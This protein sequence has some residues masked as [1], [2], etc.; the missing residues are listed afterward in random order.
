MKARNL[1][2]WLLLFQGMFLSFEGLSQTS[3][4]PKPD[5]SL[6][7]PLSPPKHP[8]T[9]TYFFLWDQG[10]HLVELVEAGEFEQASTL[11]SMHRDSFFLT[12]KEKFSDLVDR[13]SIGLDKT[14]QQVFLQ[15][16]SNLQK[17][18]AEN[19]SS[20]GP[21]RVG[22]DAAQKL[23]E[24][25]VSLPAIKDASKLP[26][27][28]TALSRAIDDAR[29]YWIS[30]AEAAFLKFDTKRNFF[31]VYPVTPS[32]PSQFLGK[33]VPAK[34]E[35]LQSVG[36]ET[37]LEFAKQYKSQLASSSAL[38][39]LSDLYVEVALRSVASPDRLK[40]A[41]SAL[42]EAREAGLK[43][44]RVPGLRIGFVEATSQTLLKEGQIEFPVAIEVNLP[45][46]VKKATLDEAL[47]DGPN[48]FDYVIVVDVN[49][50][51]TL[52]R[53][54]KRDEI[55]SEFLAGSRERPN[56]AYEQA[57]MA[58]FQAQSE[59][60]NQQGQYCYGYGCIAKAIAV[61]IVAS[62]LQERQNI[63]ASTPM[64]ITDPVYNE[65]KFSASD[66][67]ARKA[68][69]AN[70]YVIDL[71]NRV[72]FKSIFEVAEEKSFKIAYRL[73]EKDKNLS[74]HLRDYSSESAV[75]AFNDAPS[76]VRLSDVLGQYIKNSGQ[77]QALKSA[78]AMRE[79]L[80]A[81]KNVALASYKETSRLQSTTASDD[82]RLASVV[83]IH[84][85]KGS[86]GTG[87]FVESD[88]VLTN[89]H[90][91]EGSQFVEMKL[92]SGLETFGKVVKTDA[93]LDLALVKV[94][95][96]GA[97]VTF[98]D[99]PIPLG[100]TVEAIGH[101][102][103]LNFSITRG[104]ISAV[105]KRPALSGVGGKEVTFVQTDTPI[106]PGN[107]GGPLFLNGKVVGVND[108]K[109]SAKGIEGIAFSIHF[110]EVQAFLKESF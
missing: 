47:A 54:Q 91:V 62:K 16:A 81:D 22:L 89:Y 65:Y 40:V 74:Q 29:A 35:K 5:L 15:S 106:N 25:F 105:R 110:T 10:D 21:A 58:V 2:S 1:L 70:Y 75:K 7:T 79:E 69:A 94:Q 6:A 39:V 53:V 11:Y 107:S 50:A 28:A 23:Y 90:V 86:I 102:A 38:E 66:V 77:M 99:G 56:P 20:W 14:Y 100:S 34:R 87:F 61:G 41:S 67:V 51:R 8:P 13:L 60:N 18:G 24:A 108:F 46:D 55:P 30:A 17:S 64:T 33:V 49:V 43:P 48:Q 101:P 71:A 57:R 32:E 82:S 37:L 78:V 19:E 83:V 42:D 44:N 73:H 26:E 85:P 92:H 76:T 109:Y 12:R 84:N 4:I 104:V 93:R 27:N 31:E 88:L 45:F 97:P 3:S 52:Q 9:K 63:F 95:A 36:R 103:G 98:H 68:V 72:Y 80:L 96:R 59:L